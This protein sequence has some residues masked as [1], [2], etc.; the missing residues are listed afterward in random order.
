MKKSL[1]MAI[2]LVIFVAG[3]VL[4]APLDDYSKAGNVGI[5]IYTIRSDSKDKRQTAT[6]DSVNNTYFS[7]SFFYDNKWNWGGEITVSFAP[8][9]AFSTDYSQVKSNKGN[10]FNDGMHNMNMK[11]K[12][13]STN[14]KLKYQAYKDSRIFIAPYL[15]V[16]VNK[17]RQTDKTVEFTGLYS[18]A[19]S[20]E[21]KRKSNLLA[22]LTLVYS[23]DKTGSLKTYFDAAVGSNVYSYNIGLSYRLA[24]NLDLDFGYKYSQIK[25][26][27]YSYPVANYPNTFRPADNGKIKNTSKGI[28]FGLSYKFT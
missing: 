25:N 14:I 12:L 26:L 17:L 10:F 15:G 23:L 20:F 3:G 7:R 2:L 22:G 28:Y 6:D 18:E 13:T 11:T 9:W 4:A 16:A 27:K 24:K 5:S 21:S 1:F 8:C 19:H